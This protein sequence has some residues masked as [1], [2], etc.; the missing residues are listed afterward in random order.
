MTL[1]SCLKEGT[2]E[3][4]V[5]ETPFI[6]ETKYE[7]GVYG[8]VEDENGNA[9]ENATIVT[10]S[11]TKTTAKYGIFYVPKI[12]IGQLSGQ[13]IKAS[14]IGYHDGGSRIYANDLGKYFAKI[15]LIKE[16]PGK[17]IQAN[18]GGTIQANDNL[19]ITFP[20]NAFLNG[21]KI[22]NGT[23]NVFAHYTDPSK[24]D[25]LSKIPG[26]L[27]AIN[28]A[29]LQKVI[30]SYGIVSVE[31]KGQNGELLELD[32]TKG[33]E[34]SFPIPNNL[35]NGATTSIPVWNFDESKN[36]WVEEELATLVNDRY[37]AKVKHFSWWNIGLPFEGV[38]L[39]VKL[40]Q[41]SGNTALQNQR[42]SLTSQ[43]HSTV[44]ARTNL[45]G[46]VCG[47]I[48]RNEVLLFKVYDDCNKVIFEKEVGPFVEFFNNQTIEINDVTNKFNTIEGT[49][50]LC[51]SAAIVPDVFVKKTIGNH[52][53]FL[54]TD[55]NGFYSFKTL[56]CK[57]DDVNVTAIDFEKGIGA[58]I[59]IGNIQPELYTRNLSLC[60]LNEI[61][62]LKQDGITTFGSNKCKAKVRPNETIIH[63]ASN[64]MLGFNG[65]GVGTFPAI[66]STDSGFSDDQT[67]T[68]TIQ[69][70]G[71]SNG[72]IKGT[73]TGKG[74]LLTGSNN[75]VTWSG[76]F[77][78][79][80]N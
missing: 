41:A 50:S 74:K 18:Q 65:T 39:S 71:N 33:A 28:K 37:I 34:I 76:S 10:P 48:P 70:Y 3:T 45:K 77:I 11:M 54:L 79:K 13:Y 58:E 17:I 31:L 56:H 21:N 60:E 32:S 36:R 5:D 35:S 24:D 44:Y 67:F 66:M 12:N 51:T 38:A 62:E 75:T 73:F 25:F 23:V 26:D 29:G 59:T 43:I 55:E 40:I 68:V 8:V 4:I 63:S 15:I 57:E 69:E 53:V 78:A 14:A 64:F 2:V 20:T 30:K 6:V 7:V 22:Y 52:S 27:S 80:R 47:R 19:S 9:I 72:Y 1:V 49:V 46:V 61:I 42:V 16:N